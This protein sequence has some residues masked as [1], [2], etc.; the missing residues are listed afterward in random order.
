[1]EGFLK[2]KFF[3]HDNFMS[4]D[5]KIIKF[6]DNILTRFLNFLTKKNFRQKRI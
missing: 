5:V 6:F 2:E 3:N 4:I 1:M